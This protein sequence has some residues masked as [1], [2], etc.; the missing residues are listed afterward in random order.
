MRNF[1]EDFP[2]LNEE[3]RG[4]KLIYLDSAA[5]SQ[6]PLQ[7]LE[8]VMKYDKEENGNPHRGSHTLSLRATEAFESVREK[9]RGFL[10]ARSTKEIIFTKNATEAINLVAYSYAL[11]EVRKGDNMV[12]TIAG[13]MPILSHG[14][15]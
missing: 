5:T 13:I 3:V 10:N 4:Q 14:S 6:R 11:N 15:R 1:R 2:I 9:V 12:I 7:V 8:A